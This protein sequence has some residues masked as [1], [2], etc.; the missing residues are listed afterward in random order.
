MRSNDDLLSVQ[1]NVYTLV[2]A[3]GYLVREDI[4]NGRWRYP[5]KDDDTK[6]TAGSGLILNENEFS[7]DF[8]QVA[9]AYTAGNGLS[10]SGQEFSINTSIVATKSDLSNKDAIKV[11]VDPI[12]GTFELSY[13]PQ[14]H[15]FL[16]EISLSSN[17]L[18]L[19]KIDFTENSLSTN[20]ST[21]IESWIT[22]S[23]QE[24]INTIVID[25]DIVIVN[26]LPETLSGT[27][28]H[29]FVRRAYKDANSNIHEA[30]NY[31]Y[32]F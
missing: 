5:V 26:E 22:T 18:D 8:T 16:N 14:Y 7:I 32:S 17:T 20:E 15:I 27:L 31:A 4:K 11:D 29:V 25:N 9:Q 1:G 28:T 6:Y 30:I 24:N 3:E 10:L 21:T 12:S 23:N 2:D 19:G 13:D